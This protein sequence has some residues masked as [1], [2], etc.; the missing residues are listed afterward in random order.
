MG[1]VAVVLAGCLGPVGPKS[2]RS[3][4]ARIA[5]E[6]GF[7]K[8]D[9][10]VQPIPLTGYIKT[11]T[12]SHTTDLHVY[13]ERDGRAWIRS[14]L[15]SPDPTPWNPLGLKLALSDPRS[16]ILYLTRPCQYIDLANVPA[17]TPA[18]WTRE[19]FSAA[20][21]DATSAAIESVVSRYGAEGQPLSLTLIGY[22]GGGVIA[23]MI[24]ADR[25]DVAHLI[26]VAAPLDTAAWTRKMKVDPMAV[27]YGVD[28]LAHKLRDLDQH[29]FAG[30]KDKIVPP[31]TLRD[32]AALMSGSADFHL[33]EVPDFDHHCC[34]VR[35]W[36]DLLQTATETGEKL[37]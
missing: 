29:H 35:E 7:T 22:S 20:A 37:D 36:P 31:V 26:T 34:W 19:R 28:Q 24:A 15:A 33:T 13:I 10:A 27:P 32:F 8:V 17:C 2:A 6:G 5:Q 9:F 14:D 25:K 11:D 3:F 30:G 21:I 23:A 18:L 4:A 1:G 16:D 12:G